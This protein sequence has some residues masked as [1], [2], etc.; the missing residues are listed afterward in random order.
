MK[1]ETEKIVELVENISDIHVLEHTLTTLT[2]LS[3]TLK[4]HTKK[5]S[6]TTTQPTNFITVDKFA[7]AQ[8]MSCNLVSNEQLN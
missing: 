5:D 2:N 3:A 4:A 7:P 6:A 1:H 8:K